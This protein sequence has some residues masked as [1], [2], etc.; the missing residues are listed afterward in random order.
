ME[1]EQILI[2]INKTKLQI[3]IILLHYQK[4]QKIGNKKVK[5]DPKINFL[6]EILLKNI[7][8]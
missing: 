8:L 7:Q 1:L 2:L 6:A 5:L 4:T 3:V